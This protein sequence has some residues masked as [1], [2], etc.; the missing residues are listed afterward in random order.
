LF[1]LAWARLR[2]ASQGMKPWLRVFFQKK[3]PLAGGV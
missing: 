2:R 1:K 3:T